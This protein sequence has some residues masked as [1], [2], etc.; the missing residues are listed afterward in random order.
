V[1]AKVQQFL[2]ALALGVFAASVGIVMLLIPHDEIPLVHRVTDLQTHYAALN[3]GDKLG[4]GTPWYDD[5]EKKTEKILVIPIDEETFASRDPVLHQFPFPRSTYGTLLKKLGAAGAKAVAF[6]IDFIEPS[7]DPAQDKVFAEGLRAIPTVLAYTINTTS[8]GSIGV[9]SPASSLLPFSKGTG[10]STVD[11]PGRVFIGQ[12]ME[13]KTGASGSG[14]NSRL[15][16]LAAAG[17]ELYTGKK[18]DLAKLPRDDDGRFLLVAPAD[19]YQQHTTELNTRVEFHVPTFSTQYMSFGGAYEDSV[20]DLSVAAKGALVYIGNT[21]QAEGDFVPTARTPNYPG[22]FAN[23]RLADQLMR[24]IYITPVPMWVNVLLILLLPMLL[25]IAFNVMKTTYAIAASLA[26]TLIY[27]YVNAGLFVKWLVWVDL[28]HVVISMV[29]AT[30]FVGLYRIIIEGAQRRMVTNLFGM[31][32]SPAIVNDILSSEDPKGALALKG[33][34]VKATI[35]YSDIRGFTAMSETMTPEAIYAQLNEYF[36]EMCAIIF[37]YGGYVDKFIGDCV[38]AVFSAPYQTPDDA[39]NAVLAAVAQ[40]KKI[41]E[42]AEK[43]KAEGKRPFTVGMGV[44]TGDV[45]MG[46]LGSS[47]RMNYTVIGDNVN[48]AARL[49]NVALAGEIIISDY[50]YQEVKDFVVAEDRDPVTVKGKKEPIS[51]YNITDVKVELK[52]AHDAHAAEPTPA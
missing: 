47:S 30:L 38:M 45:V 50:T 27:A 36:E 40:Q 7:V 9:V 35:F 21:A 4:F 37:E 33:K 8:S 41:L 13:I 51:I 14:A 1:S 26:T 52:P 34:K 18:L 28:D 6:D 25:S 17:V 12:P 29:L 22:L 44:N 3:V 2:I 10:F 43:W 39:K 5:S 11:T 19:E 23:A 48:L 15:L 24:G 16:S 32:V 46:N 31:H 20:K 42:L 49:Y